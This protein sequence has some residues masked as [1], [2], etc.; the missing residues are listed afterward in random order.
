MCLTHMDLVSRRTAQRAAARAET[1]G[2]T[3]E[4]ARQLAKGNISA[5][6]V[7]TLTG[8]ASRLDDELRTELLDLDDE[9]ALM[10]ASKTPEQFGR[11]VR[12]T[13]QLLSDDDGIERSE[14]QRDEAH[15]NLGMN[16]ATGMGE[17]RG[18]LHP[19]DW[20]KVNRRIDAEIAALR[21]LSEHATKTHAQLAAIALVN[22]VCSNRTA[23]RVQAEVAIHIG[24]DSLN[25]VPGA[26]KFGEYIDGTPVPAETVR[27]YACDANIIPVVL[28]GDGLPLDVGRSQRLATP[29][30]RTALLSMY[31][32][33]AVDGCNTSL[34]RCEIHHR[35]RRM[36]NSS[37]RF[38]GCQ[39][40]HLMEL[41][42]RLAVP[43]CEPMTRPTLSVECAVRSAGRHPRRR[44]SHLVSDIRWRHQM[45]R[46]VVV[47]PI[48]LD[49]QS[50]SLSSSPPPLSSSSSSSTWLSSWPPRP[51]LSSTVFDGVVF[52]G[53][54]TDGVV[55]DGVLG[56]VSG[57][58]AMQSG[59]LACSA[60]SQL[61]LMSTTLF[62]GALLDGVVFDGVLFDGVLTDGAL[63]DVTVTVG[64]VVGAVDAIGAVGAVVKVVERV[65]RVVEGVVAGVVVTVGEGPLVDGMESVASSVATAGVRGLALLCDVTDAYE[66]IP[67]PIPAIPVAIQM[68][69][70]F[71][72]C[73]LVG[74]CFHQTTGRWPTGS[75]LSA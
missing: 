67:N 4:I 10:A 45:A 64:V 43:C 8:A 61:P 16:D 19:D 75:A 70:F 50:S 63:T 37:G 24:I 73:L 49:G 68:M 74:V 71:M 40:R 17:I 47:V 18:E 57:A 27:R 33:C 29:A 14:Q 7:D 2:E 36:T 66:G 28:S 9:L 60:S 20:Q 54:L 48:P 21:K 51:L 31:R 58:A 12:K 56:A 62:D 55:F 32:T 52:E 53:V 38:I 15:L 22:L 13:I 34:D 42:T 30:Q 35:R 41:E 39:P 72:M 65:V 26:P 11:H 44:R 6:H 5:E 1:L 69:D 23:A 46:T 3:P 25:G 59:S